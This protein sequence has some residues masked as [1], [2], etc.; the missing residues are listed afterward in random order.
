MNNYTLNNNQYRIEKKLGEGGFGETFLAVDSHSPTQRKC[1]IKQLKP[2]TVNPV[3]YEVIQDRFKRE[4]VLLERLGDGH[5][6]IPRLYAYFSENN[7]FYL[8]QEYIE[9][10]SLSA[11]KAGTLSEYYV[12]NL[13]LNILPVLTYIHDQGIVHRDIKPDNIMMRNRD[14]KPVLIDFGAVRETMST[15]VSASGNPTSSIIIGTPGYMSSEQA[16]GKPIFSSDLYSLGLTAIYLLTGKQPQELETDHS[17]G[18]IIWRKFAPYISDG[19]AQVLDKAIKYHPRDRFPSAQAMLQSLEPSQSPYNQPYNQP[20]IPPTIPVVNPVNPTP[21][22]QPINGNE[23]KLNP[24]VIIASIIIGFSIMVGLVFGLKPQ[25]KQPDLSQKTQEKTADVSQ[26]PTEKPTNTTPP[27]VI[28][29]PSPEEAVRSYYSLINN[30][31]YEEGWNRFNPDLRNNRKL[32]PK[33]YRSYTDWWT[34]VNYVEV[35]NTNLIS[36]TSDTSAVDSRLRYTM[37][38]RKIVK[39]TLRFYFIWDESS[40]SWLINKVERLSLG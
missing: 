5:D 29:K 24:S 37:N 4:A 8:V 25:E 9:G 18:E 36:Q 22:T 6:Q 11:L 13:L 3:I 26:K 28:E 17:T 30:R 20:S 40:R 32:H 14:N 38:N 21:I 27:P 35:V 31:Q 2:M 34:K 12:K 15:T 16:I 10:E 33:G 1:V 7:Q 39:Q 19:F 23:S